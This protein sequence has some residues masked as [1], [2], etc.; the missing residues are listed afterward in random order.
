M[1]IGISKTT[2]EYADLVMGIDAPKT[3]WMAIAFSLAH[4]L[5][6]G[7]TQD[8]VTLCADEWQLLHV[9]GIVPQKPRRA[10]VDSQS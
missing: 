2:N 9:N 3:V 5:V 1:S 6:D 7:S 4:R 10:A 8:A